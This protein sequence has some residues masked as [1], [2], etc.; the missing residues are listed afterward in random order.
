[1]KFKV[2]ITKIDGFF[3][4]NLD[5]PEIHK[6]TAYVPRMSAKDEREYLESYVG[7]KDYKV[8]S[9]IKARFP[10]ELDILSAIESNI[11]DIAEHFAENIEEE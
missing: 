8:S 2:L 3:I 7:T 4:P 9:R 1:M 5:N 6:F 11:E 10:L